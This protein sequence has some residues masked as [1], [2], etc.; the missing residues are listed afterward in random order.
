[1]SASNE[2]SKKFPDFEIA[3]Y[4]NN[5]AN[6]QF[7]DF[8]YVTFFYNGSTFNLHGLH[9][10]AHGLAVHDDH[11]NIVK[12]CINIITPLLTIEFEKREQLLAKQ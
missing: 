6:V 11:Q 7:E 8:L 9:F 2:N 4:N 12:E 3:Y 5:E 10:N 1:M